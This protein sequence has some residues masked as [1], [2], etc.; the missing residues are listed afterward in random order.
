MVHRMG[1]QNIGTILDSVEKIYR[2]YPRNGICFLAFKN[3]S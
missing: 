1:E 3:E 2:S